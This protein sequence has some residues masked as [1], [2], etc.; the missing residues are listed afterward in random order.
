MGSFEFTGD[1]DGRD[2]P[3]LPKFCNT[4]KFGNQGSVPKPHVASGEFKRPHYKKL[5]ACRNKVSKSILSSE[6]EDQNEKLNVPSQNQEK[7]R[8]VYGT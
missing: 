2:R 7:L 4:K 6:I 3:Q 5:T 1:K 8:E